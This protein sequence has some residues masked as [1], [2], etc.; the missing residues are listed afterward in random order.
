MCPVD[1]PLFAGAGI[2]PCATYE[3]G[4][5]R[6][7]ADY[8]FDAPYDYTERSRPWSTPGLLGRFHIEPT[9]WLRIE[10]QGGAM[11]PTV[12][13]SYHYIPHAATYETPA[14]A[15]FFGAGAGVSFP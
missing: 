4:V 10:V 13:D 8:D 2:T 1:L 14:V 15:G 3:L 5:V 6:A 7:E 11:F 12:R 9:D